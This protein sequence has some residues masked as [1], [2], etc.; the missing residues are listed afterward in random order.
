MFSDWFK[1]LNFF[2]FTF[3]ETFHFAYKQAKSVLLE[4]PVTY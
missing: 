2:F 3:L 4:S 1:I